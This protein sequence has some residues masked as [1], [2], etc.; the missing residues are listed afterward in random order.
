MCVVRRVLRTFST[1]FDKKLRLHV[2]LWVAQIR[3]FRFKFRCFSNGLVMPNCSHME[4]FVA[5]THVPN[6]NSGRSQDIRGTNT[7][8]R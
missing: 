3:S 4:T 7:T 6:G 5:E 1:S 8:Y 2:A